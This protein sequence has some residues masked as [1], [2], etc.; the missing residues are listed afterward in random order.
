MTTQNYICMRLNKVDS[1]E[2]IFK[3]IVFVFARL[4]LYLIFF[5]GFIIVFENFYVIVFVF[6]QVWPI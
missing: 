1:G 4:Y 5:K 2:D 3:E 6:D